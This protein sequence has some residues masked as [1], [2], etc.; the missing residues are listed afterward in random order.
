MAP[1]IPVHSFHRGR[2]KS[3]ITA[4]IAALLVMQGKRVGIID[5]SFQA[6]TIHTLLGLDETAIES[7]LNDY[8]TGT[9]QIQEAVYD[10]TD[11]LHLGGHGRLFLVPA[12]TALMKFKQLLHTAYQV[13]LLEQSARLLSDTL[14]LDMVLFDTNAGLN[15]ETL[16]IIALSD[17]LLLVLRLDNQDYQGTMVTVDVAQKLSVPRIL[18]VVNEA[19]AFYQPADIRTQI[20]QTYQNPL[21]AI[22]PYSDDVLTQTAGGVFAL[23]H[24]QHP[25]TT[26]YRKLVSRLI[27]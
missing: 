13:E 9:C 19:P 7:T 15:E 2:G 11:G 23:H 12:S 26:A 8:L 22:L 20:E 25:I 21:G 16:P 5:S 18:M 1:I 27:A 24:P 17:T 3:H 10:V 6:P 4:N 14:A